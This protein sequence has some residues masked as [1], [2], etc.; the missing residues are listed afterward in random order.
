M[1][2]GTLHDKTLVREIL[3]ETFHNNPGVNSVLRKSGDRRTMLNRFF[4]YIIVMALNREGVFI[5]DNQQGAAICFV[6]NKHRFSLKEQFLRF[7]FAI[8]SMPLNRIFSILKRESYRSKQ[9]PGDGR[10]YYFWFLGVR[11]NG[12]NAGIELKNG[13][14]RMAEKDH[15][16]VY[17]ET[18]VERNKTIYQRLGFTVYHTFHDDE[19]DVTFWFM[20]KP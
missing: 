19:T 2:R 10:Y 20:R 17:L 1:R 8:T 5:S 13:I 16:P 3:S 18:T 12:E 6:Y 14:L 15:M 4:D 11:E 9:R 7:R